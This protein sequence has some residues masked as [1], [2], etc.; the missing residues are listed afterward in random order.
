MSLANRKTPSSK[1]EIIL[2]QGELAVH[3]HIVPRTEG[4]DTF[5]SDWIEGRDV[6][7]A[8]VVD[9]ER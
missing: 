4:D 8:E 7:F 5:M 3:D 6:Q 2:G 1:N 9:A